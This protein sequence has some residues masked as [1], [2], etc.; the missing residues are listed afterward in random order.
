MEG[1]HVLHAHCVHSREPRRGRLLE[2]IESLTCIR[3]PLKC[4]TLDEM[5]L[6]QAMS[7]Q[8]HELLTDA[9]EN[10]QK[11]LAFEHRNRYPKSQKK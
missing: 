9:L 4:K 11:T 3:K 5:L 8:W 7:R 1:L 6:L 10:L 2:G